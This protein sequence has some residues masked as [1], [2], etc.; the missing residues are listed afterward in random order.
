MILNTTLIKNND[1]SKTYAWVQYDAVTYYELE[2][3]SSTS[4][5]P[6]DTDQSKK[7]TGYEFDNRTGT[8][9][10]T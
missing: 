4:I 7:Y 2:A 3:G 10:L 8:F 1:S 5:E 6:S 9:T